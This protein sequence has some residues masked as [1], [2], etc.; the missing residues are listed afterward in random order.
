MP[1]ATQRLT[2][3]GGVVLGSNMAAF[4]FAA[5]LGGPTAVIRQITLLYNLG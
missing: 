2:V 4:V 1:G 5:W 3:L